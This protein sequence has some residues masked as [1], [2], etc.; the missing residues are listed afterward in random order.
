MDLESETASAIPDGAQTPSG[1]GRSSDD[2]E[3]LGQP[4]PD[5]PESPPD[6][7]RP[8]IEIAFDADLQTLAQSALK[9][10]ASGKSGL[11][12]RACSLPAVPPINK[13]PPLSHPGH[14]GRASLNIPSPSKTKP[15]HAGPSSRL[16]GTCFSSRAST[17]SYRSVGS[18]T[19]QQQPEE[20]PGRADAVS[21]RMQ[22]LDE[23]CNRA[24]ASHRSSEDSASQPYVDMKED[25]ALTRAS[26]LD[27]P[28]LRTQPFSAQPSNSQ[29]LQTPSM[30]VT[31]TSLLDYAD[32]EASPMDSQ[33]GGSTGS[34]KS[35]LGNALLGRSAFAS[36]RSA[37]AVT[38][39]CQRS[40]IQASSSSLH[41]IDTPGVAGRTPEARQD[42]ARRI[43]A[44]ARSK[45]PCNGNATIVMLVLSA[46][47]SLRPEDEACV[48]AVR[49]AASP[50]G[51]LPLAIAVTHAEELAAAKLDVRR[52]LMPSPSALADLASNMGDCIAMVENCKSAPAA[53]RDRLLGMLSSM[54]VKL[55]A[56]SPTAALVGSTA[57]DGVRPSHLP[58]PLELERSTRW[59]VTPHGRGA[60]WQLS[61]MTAAPERRRRLSFIPTLPAFPRPPLK[62]LLPVATIGGLM[63]F[64][65]LLR[66]DEWIGTKRVYEAM[67]H[68]A[69][70]A[71]ARSK[72]G[73]HS[74]S[75][76]GSA[77]LCTALHRTCAQC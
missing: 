69:A 28:P 73:S 58:A 1:D 75:G 40:S 21:R 65:L 19:P 32:M 16:L 4:S 22:S 23:A 11:A 35:T 74:G 57:A 26:G 20:R 56:P 27:D 63:A 50:T 64:K 70:E 76:L 3:M 55:S 7:H 66:F 34:G 24:I 52:W 31:D 8:S 5:R 12:S 71:R 42:C 45:L 38:M 72:A 14:S 25:P 68:A 60:A 9:G 6:L 36:Q 49:S 29:Q 54:A 53:G 59:D 47:S 15:Q 67:N 2:W 17:G 61:G 18:T 44:A 51:Q 77:S 43:L 37:G 41:V 10:G 46:A 39:C 13:R 48:L 30:V 62:L 33:H